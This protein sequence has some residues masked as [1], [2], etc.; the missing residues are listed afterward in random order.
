MTSTNARAVSYL[1]AALISSAAIVGIVI[2]AYMQFA[3]KVSSYSVA[4][5]FPPWTRGGR[6]IGTAV[7]AG[8]SILRSGRFSFIAVVH[9]NDAQYADRVIADGAWLVLDPK[10]FGGCLTQGSLQP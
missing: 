5:V 1:E 10:A 9:P 4:V 2:P 8:A 7:R 3:P 6:A